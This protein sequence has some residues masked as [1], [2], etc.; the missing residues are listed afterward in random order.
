MACTSSSPSSSGNSS[1][2]TASGVSRCSRISRLRQRLALDQGHHHVGGAVGLEEVV[3]AHDGGRAV[4]PRQRARLV[5]EALAAPGKLLGMIGRAR[6]HGGAALAQRQRRRQVLLDR[7]VAMEREVARP[8]G[9]AEGALAEDGVQL[10]ATQ[11]SCRP[12]A[13][14]AWRPAGCPSGWRL[15]SAITARPTASSIVADL[16][17]GAGLQRQR[18]AGTRRLAVNRRAVGRTEVLDLQPAVGEQQARMT[19]R[20]RRVASARSRSGRASRPITRPVALR[21]Q[22]VDGEI[23]AVLAAGQSCR[24]SAASSAGTTDVVVRVDAPERGC[25]W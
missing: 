22:P 5:E 9:D 11:R 18:L 20:D 6:Q 19:A 23:E 17:H 8:I 25:T 14:R 16:Q 1:R 2:S 7:D 10:V 3:H 4:E 15:F 21:H 12:A 13:R 24:G